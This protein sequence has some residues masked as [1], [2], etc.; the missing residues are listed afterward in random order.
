MGVDTIQ[1]TVGSSQSWNG[2]SYVDNQPM[3]LVDP[4]GR[5]ERPRVVVR[6]IQR[7][8]FARV[9]PVIRSSGW[10]QEAVNKQLTTAQETYRDQATV[11]L[12]WSQPVTQG[13]ERND[14]SLH[15]VSGL[16]DSSAIAA[17]RNGDGATPIVFVGSIDGAP[18]GI[19]TRAGVFG[20][21]GAAVVGDPEAAQE[22]ATAHEL[23]HAFGLGEAFI[24]RIG[25]Q[26]ISPDTPNLMN[27]YQIAP[28]L[29]PDQI[30][31]I[32]RYVSLQE[33]VQ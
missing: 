26:A 30:E 1:G 18:S 22:L 21:Y 8:L 10:S 15:T 25:E 4:D 24:A 27:D 12:V 5:Q 20:P 23:G 16:S 28:E 11:Y 6:K 3:N 9:A 17:N 32:R 31:T 33:A 2:F 29:T 19:G 13:P 7:P 14:N